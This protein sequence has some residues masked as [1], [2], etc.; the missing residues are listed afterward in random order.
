M[1]T[2]SDISSIPY[3]KQWRWLS[4]GSL[5]DNF[6]SKLLSMNIICLIVDIELKFK[7]LTS[8]IR[9]VVFPG[10]IELEEIGLCC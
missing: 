8:R 1:T 10:N 7:K 3:S 9:Y 2:P 6:T 5:G 4:V